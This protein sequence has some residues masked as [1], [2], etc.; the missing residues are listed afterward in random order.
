MTSDRRITGLPEPG[1]VCAERF[2]DLGSV[3]GGV[4]G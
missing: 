2:S 1:T 3:V 4:I